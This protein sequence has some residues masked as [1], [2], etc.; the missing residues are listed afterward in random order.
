MSPSIWIFPGVIRSFSAA[1]GIRPRSSRPPPAPICISPPVLGPGTTGWPSTSPPGNTG[2]ACIL[3]CTARRPSVCARRRRPG[4]RL[5][6]SCCWA[7]FHRRCTTWMTCRASGWIPSIRTIAGRW[8]A[9]RIPTACA[10]W[11]VMPARCRPTW[12]RPAIPSSCLPTPARRSPPARPNTPCPRLC[13]KSSCLGTAGR[14]CRSSRSGIRNSPWISAGRRWAISPSRPTRRR[15]P[16]S[17]F[18]P[19]ST[20]TAG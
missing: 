12:W 17:I 7:P 20:P 10:G 9:W 14:F 18:T 15:A 1:G 16:F 19:T 3:P 13:R 8:T 11:S 2:W 6:P 4:S 5:R